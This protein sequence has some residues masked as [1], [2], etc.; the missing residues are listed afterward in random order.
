M[1]ATAGGAAECKVHAIT[2][3]TAENLDSAYLKIAF[4]QNI[5]SARVGFP[6]AA[7]IGVGNA[8]KI[9]TGLIGR[10]A[11]GEGELIKGGVNVSL[12]LPCNFSSLATRDIRSLKSFTNC[13]GFRITPGHCT[14]P[15]A[16]DCPC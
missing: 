6:A 5:K 11:R 16:S 2:L 14:L 3:S 13:H 10:S 15:F 4:P 7:T 8:V 9:Q 1:R 12:T